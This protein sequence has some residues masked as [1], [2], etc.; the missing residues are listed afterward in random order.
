VPI[1]AVQQEVRTFLARW[2]LPARIRV[3]NGAPW[4]SWSDLPPPLALWWIGLG[5]GVIWNHKY[6]PK[7]NAKVERCQGLVESWGEPKQ[8][9]DAATFQERMEWVARMQRERYPTQHGCTRL[10]AHPALEQNERPYAC[11]P[12][13][14]Q[15]EIERVRAYLGQFRWPRSVSKV[16]R[17]SLYDHEYGVG[18]AYKGEQVWVRFDVKTSEWVVAGKDGRELIRHSAVEITKEQLCHLSEEPPRPRKKRRNS[19]AHGP[20]QPYSA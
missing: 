20:P 11:D 13:E 12:E 16:G 15:F 4:G 19:M 10:A 5:I 7:E 14:K 17:I 8:C 6:C 18:R 9:P 2:G 3:D 1:G